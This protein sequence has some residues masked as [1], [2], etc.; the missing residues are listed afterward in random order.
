[1]G[2]ILPPQAVKKPPPQRN[3]VRGEILAGLG[4]A[5]KPYAAAF[6]QCERTGPKGDKANGDNG[7]HGF[8]NRPRRGHPP[9]FF[10]VFRFFVPRVPQ[11]DTQKVNHAYG[12]CQS[13]IAS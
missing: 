13:R 9:L 8:V 4:G 11:S 6:W 2:R 1:M 10:L 5:P 7:S 3:R 12:I